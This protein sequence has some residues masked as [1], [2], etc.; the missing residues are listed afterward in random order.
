MQRKRQHLLFG[1][2][3]ERVLQQAAPA[4]LEIQM[5]NT[6]T[7]QAAVMSSASLQPGAI[8][9]RRRSR[10]AVCTLRDTSGSGKG[11]GGGFDAVALLAA[12]IT[13]C[14]TQ[15]AQRASAPTFQTAT[16]E[17]RKHVTALT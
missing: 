12:Q 10:A 5:S 17:W 14:H 8:A 13:E 11:R 15:T 16:F 2:S 6:P 3:S 4:L 7:F 1:S 9:V